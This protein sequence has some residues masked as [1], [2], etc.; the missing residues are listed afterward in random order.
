MARHTDWMRK[1]RGYQRLMRTHW[2]VTL[3]FGMAVGLAALWFGIGVALF[4]LPFALIGFLQLVDRRRSRRKAPLGDRDRSRRL[5]VAIDDACRTTRDTF[6]CISLQLDDPAAIVEPPDRARADDV[7]GAFIERVSRIVR[8]EDALFVLAPGRIALLL[9]PVTSLDRAAVLSVTER[10]RIALAD[11][12]PRS[13][14]DLRLSASMGICLDDVVADRSGE[15][16]IAAL[17]DAVTRAAR[18][19]R[20]AIRFHGKQSAP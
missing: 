2:P 19:G 3:C 7:Q 9:V 8:E 1:T 5:C 13:P 12:G 16:M 18:E 17:E 11:G 14:G 15:A 10:L 4:T 20:G 6:A